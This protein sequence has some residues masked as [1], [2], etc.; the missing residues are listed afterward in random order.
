MHYRRKTLLSRGLEKAIQ[1]V[2]SEMMAHS[3]HV[4]LPANRRVIYHLLD[5][6]N[7]LADR[8]V[9]KKLS[10]ITAQYVLPI[11]QNAQFTDAIAEH[12][13]NLATLVFENKI[14]PNVARTEADKAWEKM[15]NLGANEEARSMGNAFYAG[16]AAVECLIEVLGKDPFEGVRLVK[17]SID[18]ELDPWSSDTAHWAVAA[19]V[20][21]GSDMKSDSSKRQAFWNWWLQDAIPQSLNL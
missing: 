9:F 14:S 5:V 6:N 19:Y 20:G 1:R 21:S 17:N 18:S 3:K 16:Q 13:L 12:M 10:I 8:P 4:I 7:P 2:S 15:E 11:W